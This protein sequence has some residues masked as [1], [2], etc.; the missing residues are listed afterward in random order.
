MKKN[1]K[2]PIPEHEIGLAI[3]ECS[4]E[5]Y[6]N[7]KYTPVSEIISNTDPKFNLGTEIIQETPSM[8]S[9]KN[10]PSTSCELFDSDDDK[11]ILSAMP[12]PKSKAIDIKDC[13]LEGDEE[14]FANL[15]IPK[16]L[17]GK[18]KASPLISSNKK[19]RRSDETI[20]KVD[21]TN[22][23]KLIE[24]QPTTSKARKSI[25]AETVPNSENS[26]NTYEESGKSPTTSTQ[27]MEAQRLIIEESEIFDSQKGISKKPTEN[28][29]SQ[30]RRIDEDS[31]EENF[32]ALPAKKSY[33]KLAEPLKDREQLSKDP[34]V[35]EVS[36][37]SQSEGFI[38]RASRNV[39]AA[40]EVKE[41]TPKPTV[42]RKKLVVLENNDS[43]G[44]DDF[45]N[46]GKKL[47]LSD[48]SKKDEE[49]EHFNFN[50][51]RTQSKKS[52]EWSKTSIDKPKIK[53]IQKEEIKEEDDDFP[54]EPVKIT[55]DGWLCSSIRT[56][57]KE[58]S[59]E[60]KTEDPNIYPVDENWIKAIKGSFV[61]ETLDSSTFLK[62]RS[63]SNTS[64]TTSNSSLNSTSGGKNFKKFVKVRVFEFI[65]F[66]KQKNYIIF[67]IQ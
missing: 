2:R 9:E 48:E 56:V 35:Q 51:S 17:E 57:K 67:G 28:I 20:K 55:K 22:Q 29:S 31:D 54:I 39:K 58:N 30:K 46:F 7:P 15:E 60:I 19:A 42:I 23:S 33:K 52:K 11:E 13:S 40:E 49:D 1:K 18:R 21:T 50:N 16:A 65:Y 27:K 5:K 4:T 53:T 62:S 45:F 6:C 10:K 14:I 44:E 47:K 12:V 38:S 37:S 63:S 41:P 66:Y 34:P 36:L 8:N 25:I 59:S 3:L 32:F 26:S 24:Q 61:V 64:N 43:D